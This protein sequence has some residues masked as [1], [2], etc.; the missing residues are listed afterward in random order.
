MEVLKVLILY[1]IRIFNESLSFI[2]LILWVLNSFLLFLLPLSHHCKPV[3]HYW[4]IKLYLIYWVCPYSVYILCF[5]FSRVH[6]LSCRNT[7]LLLKSTYIYIKIHTHAYVHNETNFLT[8]L[9]KHCIGFFNV[10]FYFLKSSMFL[11]Y[12]NDITEN[13]LS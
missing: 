11:C 7:F 9:L 6:F 2:Y 5:C 4:V 3:P 13:S 8:I 1:N 12:Y 10:Y